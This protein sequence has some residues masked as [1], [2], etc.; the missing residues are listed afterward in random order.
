MC[1]G[2]CVCVNGLCTE[3][4]LSVAHRNSV[5]AREAVIPRLHGCSTSC[6][7]RSKWRFK[8]GFSLPLKS[9]SNASQPADSL[10]VCC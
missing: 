1:V 3:F 4:A 8:S 6:V 9:V 7:F 5:T 2:A 10:S